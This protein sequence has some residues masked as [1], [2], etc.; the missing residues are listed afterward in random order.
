MTT[1][2][3]LIGMW[4]AM[5]SAGPLLAQSGD[6]PSRYSLIPSVQPA[7]PVRGR[8]ES[9]GMP[10]GRPY[11]AS[12]GTM[13]RPFA[14]SGSTT[15]LDRVTSP[16][17]TVSGE[18]SDPVGTLT[19]QPPVGTGLPPGSYP[20]PY[21]TDGPGCCG[22]L[23]RNG[24]IGYELYLYTGPT[25]AFGEGE[26]TRR[27]QTGWMVGGGGR[28]LFFNP[29]HTAAWVVDLGLSYQYNRGEFDDPLDVFVRQPPIQNPITGQTRPQPDILTRVSIRALN[30]T[31]FNYALGRDCWFWGPGSTG[32][33]Q[34]INLR[35][36][37]LVGGRW[38][39]AHVDMVPVEDPEGYARRQ[40]V[41]LGVFLAGH[42]TIEVPMGSTIWFAG[43]RTEWG[44][45]WTNLVPVNSGNI[46]NFNLLL[47]AGIRF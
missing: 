33:E 16:I 21:F 8:I 27:L 12:S 13:T 18:T 23:G 25:W 24:R 2:R 22:P 39:T 44:Y 3:L 32:M 46:H 9:A 29:D 14:A 6:D 15:A 7:E 11:A 19:G 5:I 36:G 45:D 42:A 47:T 26:F 34:A 35:I 31:N 40:N 43:L 1:T 28:S 41:T 20:S 17:R 30:R 10:S 37:G 4:V 38:G